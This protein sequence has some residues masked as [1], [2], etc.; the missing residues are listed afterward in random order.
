[1]R[2]RR[3]TTIG[4]VVGAAFL[5][6]T[7]PGPGATAQEGPPV[8]Q[9]AVPAACGTGPFAPGFGA[10]VPY[11]GDVLTPWEGGRSLAW[12]EAVVDTDG[13]GQEDP[14][15][16]SPTEV[17]LVRSSGDLVLLGATTFPGGGAI[18]DLDGDGRTEVLV[19]TGDEGPAATTYLVRGATPDG[20][21]AVADVGTALPPGVFGGRDVGDRDGDGR[22][23]VVLA[24]GAP[25]AGRSIVVSGAELLAPGPG[26]T[27]VEGPGVRA[28]HDGIDVGR[29]A[30]GSGGRATL[31]TSPDLRRA[32]EGDD[33]TLVVQGDP[34]VELTTAG[35]GLALPQ[36]PDAYPG[37]AGVVVAGT[38][39]WVT[40]FVPASTGDHT[41]WGWNLSDLCDVVPEPP[42]ATTP[43]TT[44]APA[45]AAAPI[46]ADARF[47]G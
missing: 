41:L 5:A 14:T 43:T 9:P 16:T 7:L 29:V 34:V 39:V 24:D 19:A 20:T 10:V 3:R 4:A 6:A 47:T 32:E 45:P 17:T 31:I 8:D 40:L 37:V 2:A 30:F 27:Y 21:H 1:M 13:D 23:D 46:R 12:P 11:R 35:S 44:P 42:P 15:G 33:A 26:G 22:P 18:G 25:P 36:D 38:A 28:T